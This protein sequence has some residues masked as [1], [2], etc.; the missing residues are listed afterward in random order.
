[1]RLRVSGAISRILL[2][3]SLAALGSLNLKTLAVGQIA[4]LG[5]VAAF[6][7]LRV[8]RQ[9]G[10][11]P[12][13]GAIRRGHVRSTMLY[14][15][16][17]GA[18]I[19][20][21]DGDKFVLNAAHHQ[22][23]AGRYG[24]AYRL[25]GVV[26]LPIYALAGATHVS[27]LDGTAGP[28]GQV[29]RAIRLSLVGM[30]YAVPAIVALEIIAP[31]IPKI[32]GRDFAETT[33]ILR[34]LAPVVALRGLGVFPMNGLM[35]LGRNALRMKLLVSNALLSLL[36]YALLIPGYSWTGALVGT[37]VS[38]TTLAISAWAALLACERIQ[39][40]EEVSRTGGAVS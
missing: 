15:I 16:G 23:D 20:Q 10:V 8:S 35:G 25:M 26:M 12:R 9:L 22:A 29:R 7:L 33:V 39:R 13:F 19:A 30:A 34:L 2:L 31:Y 3:T 40:T 32:L 18:S 14:G 28:G 37:L 36:L 21:A 11:A 24:A 5:A 1:M 4:T 38:E 17:I 27:F 6:A